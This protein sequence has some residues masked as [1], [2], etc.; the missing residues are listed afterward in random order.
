LCIIDWSKLFNVYTDASDYMVDEVLSQTGD[1]RTK[2]PTDFYSKKLSET[3]INWSTIEKDAFAVLEALN[4]FRSWIFGYK[5][6]IYSDHN[7]L[8]YLT[9]SVPKSA[10]LLRWALALQNFDICFRYEAGK[11]NAMAA[12]DCLSRMGPDDDGVKSSAE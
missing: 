3:Q 12:P 2:H 10:K 7:P 9:E 8:W 6:F 5:I 4:R 11:S 1:D